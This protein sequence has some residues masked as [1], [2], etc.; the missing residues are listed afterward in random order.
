MKKA[1]RTQTDELRA[2]YKRSDFPQGFVRGKYAARLRESSNVVVLD[3]EVARAFPNQE[4]VN[5]ALRSLIE[6]AK[7]TACPANHS[8]TRAKRRRAG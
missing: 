6:I 3:P 5:R 7:K 2:E 8:T 4:A 1:R